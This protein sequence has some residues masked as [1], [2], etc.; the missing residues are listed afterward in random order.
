MNIVLIYFAIKYKGD[1]DKIYKALTDREQIK[2]SEILQL[3]EKIQKSQYKIITL[4]D[5][6]YPKKFKDCYKP[7]FVIWTKGNFSLLKNKMIALTGDEI[8]NQT[9]KRIEENIEIFEKKFN[10][11]TTSF[12]GVDE[13]ILKLSKKPKIFI[14]ANG[15]KNYYIN[16][17]F[18]KNDLMISEYPPETNL[19]KERFR[20]RNR[21][22][23]SLGDYLVLFS[24]KKDGGINNAITNFLNMGKDIYC[25][26]GN[27]EVNDGNSELVKQGAFLI[28]SAN[29]IK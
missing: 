10:I 23:A 6:E 19:K 9:K 27:G 5:D 12:K 18:N 22:Y 21:L 15:I 14:L 20:N 4:I 3:E 16:S 7:P 2:N 1:W 25:F 13:Y 17:A 29:D 26:P 8:N 11:V 24:S 28:T